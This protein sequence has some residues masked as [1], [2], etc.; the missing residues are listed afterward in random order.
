MHVEV[1][2][3]PLVAERL[4][5][6]RDRRTERPDFRRLLREISAFLV[7][8]A[9]RDQAITPIDIDTPLAPT[10][11]VSL[12]DVPL[13]VPVMRAGLGML[14]AA[15]EILPD[16]RTGFVGLRRDEETFLP[17]AYVNTV[18]EDLGERDVMVLDPMLATGGSCVHTCS[19]LREARAGRI[20]VVCVLAAP[21]GLNTLRESRTADRVVTASI[22]EH[23]D[24]KA[25]IVPGL[26]DA[27]DRQFG[28]A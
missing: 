10:V 21:E 5:R 3:H 6:L 17:H 8:E 27:G 24:D 2:E 13:L 1:I 18:P 7:Y 19:L 4:T 28:L 16:A 15:L 12:A 11:G 23:L 9:T 22:D 20:T 25:F 14:D 26:G